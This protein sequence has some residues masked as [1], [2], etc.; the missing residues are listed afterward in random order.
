MGTNMTHM[1]VNFSSGEFVVAV[2]NPNMR[3]RAVRKADHGDWKTQLARREFMGMNEGDE[4]KIETV[5]DNFEGRWCRVI[6][7]GR[8]ADISPKD[9]EPIQKT[10]NNLTTK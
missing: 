7:G 9:L 10:T 2:S 1:I 3:V 4:G 5:F 6:F 8:Y